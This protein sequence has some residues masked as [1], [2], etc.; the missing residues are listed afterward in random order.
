MFFTQTLKK[1]PPEVF[2]KKDFLKNFTKFT[3]KRLCQ[4]LFFN[5]IAGLRLRGGGGSDLIKKETDTG[6]FL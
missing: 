2:C 6:V 3:G 4:S 5:K 1:Q